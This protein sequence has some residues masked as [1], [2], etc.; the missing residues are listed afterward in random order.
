MALNLI[1]LCVG[2]DTVEELAD[3]QKRRRAERAAAG[4]SPYSRHH[5]RNFPRRA[6]EIMASG[7][8]LYW[9]IRREIRVRQ[10]LHAIEEAV[11]Q[12]GRPCCALVFEPELVRVEPRPQR[13]FQGWRYLT[14]ADAPPDL[15]AGGGGDV[16]DMP[17]EMRRELRA[18]GLI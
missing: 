6:D 3:W 18:L 11:D 13:P 14:G 7:G 1:K 5:T 4:L 8:S 17:E 9:V 12:E 2:V 10:Q 15:R 16:G